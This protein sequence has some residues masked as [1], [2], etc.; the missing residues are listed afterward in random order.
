MQ[1][2]RKQSSL[3]QSPV[4]AAYLPAS[5]PSSATGSLDP[6]LRAAELTLYRRI[7][8]ITNM[9]PVPHQVCVCYLDDFIAGSKGVL[10]VL[11]YTCAA[12]ALLAQHLASCCSSS[13]RN[14]A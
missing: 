13:E 1:S 3:P 8:S 12:L 10:Q 4:I 6:L 14:L 11:S 7:N 2:Y 5:T 9:L